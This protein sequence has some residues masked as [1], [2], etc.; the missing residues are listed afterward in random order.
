MEAL[1]REGLGLPLL[2]LIDLKPVYTLISL[3]VV[4]TLLK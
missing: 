2:V 1:V 3:I 4:S